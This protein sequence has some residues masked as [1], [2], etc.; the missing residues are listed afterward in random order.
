MKTKSYRSA[1]NSHPAKV[2]VAGL[3]IVLLAFGDLAACA[4]P[5]AKSPPTAAQEAKPAPTAEAQDA[6]KI[7]ND[8]LESLVAPI[9]LYPDPLLSQV[10]VASTYPLSRQAARKSSIA[11]L[12]L[13]NWMR[14]PSVAV[15]TR[16]KSNMPS[17]LMTES[18]NTHNE[19]SARP[20]SVMGLPGKMRMAVGV[21]RLERE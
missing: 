5:E 18:I 13:T 17:K 15:M 21:V 12:E 11:A 10:L 8:Q 19:S 14:L 7:P 9:A 6:P 4:H 1:F 2:R 16:F 20:G 3:F